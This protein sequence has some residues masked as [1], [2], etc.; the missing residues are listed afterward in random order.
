MLVPVYQITCSGVEFEV[1]T[2]VDKK[3][4]VTPHSPMKVNQCSGG[5]C[6]LYMQGQRISQARNHEAGGK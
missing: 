6:S 3:N 5:A 2:A 4:S 1:L